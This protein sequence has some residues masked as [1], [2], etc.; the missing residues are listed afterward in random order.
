MT[1]WQ[2]ILQVSPLCVYPPVAHLMRPGKVLCSW[3]IGVVLHVGQTAGTT[4]RLLMVP[5][6]KMQPAVSWQSLAQSFKSP[7]GC[8]IC[9][10]A[11]RRGRAG[12]S[13]N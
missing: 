1:E 12:D 8:P 6:V 10:D 5:Q 7:G 9:S 11:L 2:R 13:R 3:L 4:P